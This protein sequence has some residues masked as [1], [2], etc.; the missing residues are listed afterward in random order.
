M[1]GNHHQQSARFQTTRKRL[2]QRSIE[3]GEFVVDGNSQCLKHARR[4]MFVRRFLFA[5]GNGCRDGLRQIAHGSEGMCFS[6]AYDFF[7][8]R[9]GKSFFTVS[10]EDF[11]QLGY[12]PFVEQFVSRLTLGTIEPHVEI[13]GR[14]KSEPARLVSQLIRR[15][16]QVDQ[17]PIDLCDVSSFEDA[18]EIGVTGLNQ[19]DVAVR[20]VLC[21]EFEHHFVAIESNQMAGRT[22]LFEDFPAVTSGTDRPVDDRQSR[23]EL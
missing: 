18:I 16:P 20:Q 14:L 19:R 10:F 22:Q 5:N 12:R 1:K 11:G 23:F 21:G 8:D 13:S 15:Q 6:A 7:S 17:N 2:R 3:V 9:S 4:R